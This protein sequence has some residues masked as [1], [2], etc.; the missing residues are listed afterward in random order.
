MD[1]PPGTA[2]GG[3]PGARP[4]S[5]GRPSL[6]QAVPTLAWGAGPATPSALATLGGCLG[7]VGRPQAEG[8]ASAAPE[9]PVSD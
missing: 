4:G 9:S 5:P 6:A 3:G 1:T 8:G 2:G 7:S